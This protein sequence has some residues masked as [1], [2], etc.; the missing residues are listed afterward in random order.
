MGGVNKA[1]QN[2]L[3]AKGGLHF[4]ETGSS[5]HLTEAWGEAST[6]F[7]NDKR[8]QLA[9][10]SKQKDYLYSYFQNNP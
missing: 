9:E 8:R 3:A 4:L 6:R 10:A 1:K 7:H 5:G 2:H